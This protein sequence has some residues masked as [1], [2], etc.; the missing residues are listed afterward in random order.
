MQGKGCLKRYDIPQNPAPAISLFN[1]ALGRVRHYALAEAGLGEAYWRK[2]EQTKDTQWAEQAK[3]SS[4][5]AIGLNDKLA[6]VYVTLGMI[7]TGT[8]RYEEAVL[9]PPKTPPLGP[10]HFDGYPALAATYP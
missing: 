8:G 2:Y 7:H 5:A 6:Q 1:L 3:K 4:A 9:N 10:V